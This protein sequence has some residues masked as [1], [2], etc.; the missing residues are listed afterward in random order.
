MRRLL[1]VGA[2]AVAVSSG[3][4]VG[5]GSDAAPG[6]TA[7]ACQKVAVAAVIGGKHVCLKVGQLCKR[8]LDARYH[9]YGFHCHTTGRLTK[10]AP[11]AINPR[12]VVTGPEEMV[13]DWSRDRCDDTDIPDL[14]ARAFRDASGRVQLI[15]S[16]DVTRRM[17]GPDL[18][19]LTHDCTV[20]LGSKYNPDPAAFDDKQWISSVYT[21]DGTTVYA[22][23]HAEYQ[24][25]T[26]PGK[27]PSGQY[28]QCWWNTIVLAVSK[29]GGNSYQHL[30]PRNGL[31]AA[32]PYRYRPDKGSGIDGSEGEFG[33]SQIVR[34]PSNGYY[35]AIIGEKIQPRAPGEPIRAGSCIIRTRN[36]ADPTSWRAM[37][38]SGAFSRTFIDPYTHTGG[39]PRTYAC[40][41]YIETRPYGTDG[42][43]A[44]MPRGSPFNPSLSWNTY[45]QRWLI[46][47]TD[48]ADPETG[49]NTW[50]VYFTVSKDLRTWRTQRLV[51]AKKMIFDYTCGDPDPIAYPSVIDPASPSRSF[52]TTGK[53]A[54]LYYTSYHYPNCQQTLD[55]DLVR[56]PITITR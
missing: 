50:G 47:G 23:L 15:S 26:H 40:A 32:I 54:Y 27:C 24:G 20:V 7:A 18:G 43:P 45:L 42:R 2:V 36:L 11:Q 9:R 51:I 10:P 53:T 48:Q 55:R 29:D 1:V 56:V 16:H 52:E 14:P 38:A 19:H 35:Y 41:Q 31:V 30:G 13:F 33:P 3:F 12:I 4:A 22:L 34:N 17:V 28:F 49:A 46:V 44:D 37:D 8:A 25:N 21:T 39:S 6:V 5:S